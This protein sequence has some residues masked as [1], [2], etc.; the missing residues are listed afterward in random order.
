MLRSFKWNGRNPSEWIYVWSFL[1][2]LVR[3]LSRHPSEARTSPYLMPS[4]GSMK[5]C[6]LECQ[7]QI[8]NL[9]CSQLLRLEE[10][11]DMEVRIILP[12]RGAE[13]LRSK[14][15]G[16]NPSEWIYVWSFLTIST[17][18]AT[19]RSSISFANGAGFKK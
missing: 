2:K 5:R 1:T 18:L 7:N 16:R 12:E 13:M 10:S 3:G 14:W 19:I 15:N 17:V 9:L 4:V 6:L 11:T 8:L